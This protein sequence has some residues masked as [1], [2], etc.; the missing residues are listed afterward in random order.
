VSTP[1]RT[2][3]EQSFAAVEAKDLDAVLQC[4][5]EDAVLIDPHYP[6]PVM[7]GKAAI[8]DGL[9]WGFNSLKQFGFSIVSY[10]ELPDGKRAAI[11][12]ATHHVLPNGRHLEFPQAF[13]IDAQNNLIT[14]IQAYEPYGPPGI[15]ALILGGTRL[16][17]RLRRQRNVRIGKTPGVVRV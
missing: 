5:A 3:I 15:V 12:V 14:R 10:F 16:Q 4:F 13:F 1:L 8:A 2:L 11:E 17:R 7:D 9:R 6:S